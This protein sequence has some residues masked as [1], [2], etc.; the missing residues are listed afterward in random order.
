MVAERDKKTEEV[1][2]HLERIIE[3]QFEEGIAEQSLARLYDHPQ[4]KHIKCHILIHSK[5]F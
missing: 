2:E 5:F 4:C 3:S 1:R